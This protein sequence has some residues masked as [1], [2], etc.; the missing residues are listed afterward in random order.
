M[1]NYIRKRAVKVANHIL[2]TSD[3]VRKTAEIFGISKSTVHKDVSER[4]PRINRDLAAQVKVV[5]EQNK[6]E[7]HIRGGEA[8]RKKYAEIS[9]G[10]KNI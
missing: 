10:N 1:Q 4:L 7:R 9:L 8:T 3:T 6:A 5:L 2:Q